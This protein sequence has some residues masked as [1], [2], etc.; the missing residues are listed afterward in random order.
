MQQTFRIQSVLGGISPSQYF[1]G[2]G[3]YLGGV[4]IDPDLPITSSDVRTSGCIV[5][6]AYETFSSTPVNSA[7]IAIVTDPKDTKTYAVTSGGKLISYDS[8]LGSETTV[9]TFAGSTANGA[10][11]YNNY[12]YAT[13]TGASA[14]D[15]SRY[16]PLNG[17]PSIVD[18]VWTGST[19]G[20]QTAL[21]NTAYPTVRGLALPN[22]WGTVHSDGSAYFLDFKDGQ[23][24]VHRINTKKG[25]AEGDTD[26][27]VAPSAYNVLDLPFGFYPTAISSYSTDLAILAIQTTDATVNQGRAALFLWDPTN[28]DTFYRQIPLPDPLATA[29]LYVNGELT[30]WSGNASNGFRMSRYVGGETV[31]D[32]L[33][34][35]EGAPPFP[36]GVDALGNRIVFGSYSTYPSSTACVYGFGSKNASLPRGLH[37]VV[38]TASAGST[39]MTTAVRYVQQASNVQP[40]C[41]AAWRDGSGYGIDRLS[42]SST[43]QSVFRTGMVTVGHKFK[44]LKVRIP[45]G[46]TVASNM[47]I[48]PKIWLDDGTTSYTLSAIDSTNFPGKRAV[49]YKVPN[50]SSIIGMNNL[51]I[52]LAFGGTAQL[53]VLLPIEVDLEVYEDEPT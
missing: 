30:I 34:M 24:M 12:I 10:F 21:T 22:H 42:S 6:V 46:D 16:G 43:Y 37:N 48:V 13:G 47:S 38:R 4:A 3:Q 29:L 50:L 8:S 33:Y 32:I 15:V 1:A 18:G 26:G 14:N 39:Q 19:L 49:V 52:E 27:T 9:G 23:G 17:S 45:L 40:R 2:E 53:S 28:T 51:F 20:S 41:I 5:P 31:S 35:E 7:V 25:T 11:Y 44:V 36:G